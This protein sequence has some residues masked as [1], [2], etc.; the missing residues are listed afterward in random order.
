MTLSIKYNDPDCYLTN[1]NDVQYYDTQLRTLEFSITVLSITFI[2]YRV[3]TFCAVLSVAK[4][5]ELKAA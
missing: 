1:H 3:L 4:R 5:L 2:L